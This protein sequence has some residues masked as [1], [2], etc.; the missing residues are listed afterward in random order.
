MPRELNWHEANAVS[1][2]LTQNVLQIIGATRM[3]AV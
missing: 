2:P 3:L 1:F